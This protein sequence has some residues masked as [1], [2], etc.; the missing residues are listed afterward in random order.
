MRINR[1]AIAALVPEL[2][3]TTVEE[4]PPEHLKMLKGYI[5]SRFNSEQANVIT[6]SQV[7]VPLEI[8]RHKSICS[9]MYTFRETLYNFCQELLSHCRSV[10]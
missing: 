3:L 2:S 10:N 9:S 1:K 7:A 4:I 8:S 5:L 6:E